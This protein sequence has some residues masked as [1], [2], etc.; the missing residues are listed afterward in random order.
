MTFRYLLACST[1]NLL[2]AGVALA[3]EP[4]QGDTAVAVV[5]GSTADTGTAGTQDDR[6]PPPTPP[7]LKNPGSSSTDSGSSSSGTSSTKPKPPTATKG[8]SKDDDE[9]TTTK[10]PTT[11]KKTKKKKKKEKAETEA[12]LPYGL[13]V[14]VGLMPYA[15]MSADTKTNGNQD[16]NMAMSYGIGLDGHYRLASSFYLTAELM[17][18]WTEI[19]EVEGTDY[20][21]ESGDA[22]MDIG[23]GAKYVFLGSERSSDRVYG[24]GFLGYSYYISSDDNAIDD[25]RG[26]LYYGAA[27]GIWH[28]MSKAFSL[29]AEGGLAFHSFTN[30]GGEEKDAFFWDIQATAGF[31]YHWK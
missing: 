16:Y 13:G 10:K 15:A 24:R 14:K 12:E 27:A 25:N 23:I 29:F 11:K 30:T 17:Y 6:L 7:K 3:A 18:W 19:Q 22:M 9:G 4:A 5:A 1:L 8:D 21:A 31:M 28:K 2:L 20:N 26:G